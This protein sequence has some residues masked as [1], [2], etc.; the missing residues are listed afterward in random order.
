MVL[1]LTPLAH[2]SSASETTP[3]LTEN[4]PLESLA[5]A[6][7][8]SVKNDVR[9]GRVRLVSNT[10]E[11]IVAAGL[12]R[13][14]VDGRGF[15]L[16]ERPSY[17]GGVLVIPSD[18]A[19]LV[20][21]LGS[22]APEAGRPYRNR[23]RPGERAKVTYAPNTAGPARALFAGGTRVVAKKGKGTEPKPKPRVKTRAATKTATKTAASKKAT[24]GFIV[25]D[26]GHGGSDEGARGAKGLKEKT[27]VLDIAKRMAK[28]LR[29]AG[30]RVV[31]TRDKDTY[32]SPKKR[33]TDANKLK[34]DAFL[35]LHANSYGT[36]SVCGT[37]TW[38]LSPR[39]AAIKRL[40]KT[41]GMKSKL[42]ARAVQ[43][44]LVGTLKNRDRG[45]REGNYIVLRN[46][47]GPA[48]LVEVGFISNA[49]TEA[50]LASAKWRER[51][52]LTLAKAVLKSG[53]LVK[54]SK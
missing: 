12:S 7:G 50:R 33:A 42:L 2:A 1:A 23:P 37:E 54:R 16:L 45:V 38:I 15:P 31:M 4:A 46:S 51:I 25:L 36:C 26:P 8:F 34:P 9:T 49:K 39:V 20:R 32:I 48:A 6:F 40:P 35:S 29:K 11:I 13:A 19:D 3:F 5:K 44:A 47:K 52:A 17:V 53:V 28:H 10:H 41:T 22:G 43:K 27:V 18:L 30:V 24:I 21:R 14:L